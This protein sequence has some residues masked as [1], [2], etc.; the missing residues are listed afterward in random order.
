MTHNDSTTLRHPSG[1]SRHRAIAAGLGT[2]AGTALAA[3]LASLSSAPAAHADDFTDIVNNVESI[4]SAGDA[5]FTTGATDFADNM[6]PAGLYQDATGVDDILFAPTSNVITD[7][8]F[9]L[10]GEPIPDAIGFTLT[11]P[12]PTDFA[13][14]LA[15]AQADITTG[16]D[17]FTTAETDFSSSDFA[18][19]LEY[20]V[21]GLDYASINSLSDLFVGLLGSI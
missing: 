3:A 21:A 4:I 1:K 20:A 7:A 6:V 15:D 14:G 12:P 10:T 8:G 5:D 13:Q 19:G 17:L 9:A 11:T 2:A 18:A 16:Q